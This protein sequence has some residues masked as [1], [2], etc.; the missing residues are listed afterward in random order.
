MKRCSTSLAIR[1]THIKTTMRYHFTPVRMAVI[2]KSRYNE[3]RW[4]C[5]KRGPLYT[6]GGI[7]KWHSHYGKQY[8]VSLKKL[9]R[10]LPHDPAI[11]LWGI[12]PKE[13]KSLCWRNICTLVFIAALFTTAKTRKQPVSIDRW[14]DKEMWWWG[15]GHLM[16]KLNGES[17]HLVLVLI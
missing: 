14:L 6:V 7:V 13:M 3:C 4:G 9:E 16:W 2:K 15:E 5:E 1:E 12:Y 8:G 11:P 10:E 17:L